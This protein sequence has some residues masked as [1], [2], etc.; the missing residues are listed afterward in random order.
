[1]APQCLSN[2]D[3]KY[4][5][6]DYQTFVGENNFHVIT[7]LIGIRGR[8]NFGFGYGFGA[9]TEE[10]LSFGYGRNFW[11]VSAIFS[12]DSPDLSALDVDVFERYYLH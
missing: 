7:N 3:L 8:P 1:L 5:R 12:S 6:N 2:D 4:L 11:L 9:E 10:K